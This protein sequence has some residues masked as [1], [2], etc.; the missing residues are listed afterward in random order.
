VIDTCTTCGFLYRTP[1][2]WVKTFRLLKILMRFFFRGVKILT[3]IAAMEWIADDALPWLARQRWIRFGV[4][5]GTIV[6]G[7]VVVAWVVHDYALPWLAQRRESERAWKVW[8]KQACVVS[9]IGSWSTCERCKA[10]FALL[11][12]A[13]ADERI[14]ERLDSLGGREALRR[15]VEICK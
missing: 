10:T 11:L 4:R 3:G 2:W 12:E 9:Q 8:R 5:W 13:D 14:R 7:A 15:G 6:I 1:P